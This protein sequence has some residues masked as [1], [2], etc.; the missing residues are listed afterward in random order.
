LGVEK[1]I[2]KATLAGTGWHIEEADYAKQWTENE[3]GSFETFYRQVRQ[4]SYYGLVKKWVRIARQ[5]DFT[6]RR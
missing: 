1:G 6:T 2:E 5:P 3:I 4:C